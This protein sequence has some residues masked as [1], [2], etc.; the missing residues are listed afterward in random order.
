[1]KNL[2]VEIYN[3]N[4]KF[5]WYER[6]QSLKEGFTQIFKNPKQKWEWD[7]LKNINIDIEQGEKLAIIGRNGCG[8]TTLLKIIS[9]I[10]FP[11]SGKVNI[12]SQ[13]LLALIEL[14]V[15]FY[16]DLTGRENILLNWAFNGLPKAELKKKL[17][18]IIAFSGVEE[19]LDTPLKYFS[20][21]MTTRLGFSIAI[22]A[23]PDLLIVDEVLAVGDAEF[24]AQCYEKIDEVC[25][26]GTTLILVSH[27]L[28]DIE[29]VTERAIWIDKGE[30]AYDGFVKPAIKKYLK[31][32]N[33]AQYKT[34]EAAL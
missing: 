22:H 16:P 9:G 5:K 10:H 24:Q 15:G 34:M 20:S 25:K 14:G 26:T 32:Y 29:R 31:H 13:R 19:F 33:M 18:S 6:S 27:N 2:A 21:G 17:D 3:L 28:A 7:V 23:E 8:K 1:M 12:Y 4:K 11:T 30:I